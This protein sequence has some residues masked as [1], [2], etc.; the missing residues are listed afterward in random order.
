MVHAMIM[1]LRVTPKLCTGS[2]WASATPS[3]ID[4]KLPFPNLQPLHLIGI[5]LQPVVPIQASIASMH[6]KR[7][8]TLSVDHY[9]WRCKSYHH[10]HA[11]DI[12][13]H[14]VG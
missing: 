10:Q 7:A 13:S 9:G 11:V 6:C 1:F 5:Q 4:D 3:R 12:S 8:V 2:V 14:G